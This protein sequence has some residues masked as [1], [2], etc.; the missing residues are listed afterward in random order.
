MMKVSSTYLSQNLGGWKEE[1]LALASN[2]SMNWFAIR[3]ADG[4]AH[5]CTMDLFKLLSLEKE[6]GIFKAKLQQGND[7]LDLH[8]GLVGE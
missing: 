3:R 7:L 2:S 6:V 5:G 1:L 4:G 8:G